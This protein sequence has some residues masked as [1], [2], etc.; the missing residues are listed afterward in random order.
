MDD[1]KLNAH[2]KDA[3]GSTLDGLAKFRVINTHNLTEKRLGTFTEQTGAGIFIR[4][5]TGIQ[6]VPRYPFIK[7]RWILEHLVTYSDKSVIAKECDTKWG[8][9]CL[10]V[11]QDKDGNILPLNKN[12]ADVVV[13]FFINRHNYKR[14]A[15]EILDVEAKKEDAKKERLKDMIGEMLR[16]P[17]F[18][19]L[20][21]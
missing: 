20:V 12:A 14:A 2:L 18:G 11:F 8:Y 19:D 13:Y 10:Y 6:E 4:E 1:I 7:D 9:E 17:Y 5:V 3:Y 21:Y 16:S 15:S